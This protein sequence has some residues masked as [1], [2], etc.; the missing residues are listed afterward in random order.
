MKTFTE[1]LRELRE[2]KDLSMAALGKEIGYTY[3][4]VSRWE[5]GV[6]I[7]TIDILNKLA[8]FFGVSADY[9]LGRED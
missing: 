3:S 1:R 5:S 7:P 4:S 9:L 8:E 6:H 2:E